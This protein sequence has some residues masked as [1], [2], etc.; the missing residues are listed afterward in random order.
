MWL[1]EVLQLSKVLHRSCPDR[2]GDGLLERFSRTQQGL[3]W[4][5]L[6]E[7][8]SM[9]KIPGRKMSAPYFLNSSVILVTN[10]GGAKASKWSRPFMPFS[11]RLC[12]HVRSGIL[13][14]R[15]TRSVL[16]PGDEPEAQTP[17]SN[18]V[19]QV[20][21]DLQ[22]TSGQKPKRQ[23]FLRRSKCFLVVDNPFEAMFVNCGLC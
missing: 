3:L 7:R 8:V 23:I 12:C 19:G 21:Q 14:I 22:V 6:G 5:V 4:H 9:P 13:R 18:F 15:D 2:K 20:A 1:W 11:P 17:T 16:P 10:I